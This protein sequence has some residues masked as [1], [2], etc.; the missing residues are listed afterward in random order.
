M[1]CIELFIFIATT[2]GIKVIIS[3]LCL[4]IYNIFAEIYNSFKKKFIIQNEYIDEEESEYDI[5]ENTDSISSDE[6]ISTTSTIDN[7]SVNEIIQEDIKFS[8]PISYKINNEED[9]ITS[10][11]EI[12]IEL[13]KLYY[14]KD[15]I[16]DITKDKSYKLYTEEE[17][18]DTG[19][20]GNNSKYLEDYDIHYKRTDSFNTLLNCF[21]LVELHNDFLEIKYIDKN[22]HTVIIHNNESL[23]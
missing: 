22:L 15:N 6:S 19:F 18:E 16:I 21:K 20:I 4:F 11:T 12:Y 5:L 1:Y 23:S 7:I 8:K 2:I 9:Y 13:I 10:W 14:T 3:N 17:I